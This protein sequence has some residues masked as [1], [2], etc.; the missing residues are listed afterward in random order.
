[1]TDQ[2]ASPA[3]DAGHDEAPE[4]RPFMTIFS[5]AKPFTGLHAVIQQNALESW[6]RLEPAAQV[7]LV[8]DEEGYEEAARA[9]GAR[10]SPG[11]ERNEFGTPLIADI[12]DT[13]RRDGTG[14][15][16]VFT[17]ADIVLPPGFGR[18]IEEVDWHFDRWLAVGRRI[19]LDVTEPIDYADP[20]WY[21]KLA[22][23][24]DAEGRERGDLCI[25]WFAFDR[26]TLNEIPAF[27]IGRTRYD[28]WLIW[29]ASDEGAAVVDV[30]GFVRVI[31]QNHDYGHTGG[32]IGAWE[33]PEARRAEQLLGHWSHYHSIA[34]AT[35][36]LGA[37]G[38]IR[39]APSPRRAAARARRVASQALRFS[40]PWRR[41]ARQLAS[42]SS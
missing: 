8:G 33:G 9:T 36:V 34:H 12:F 38:V 29:K 13:G 27:A 4:V 21:S 28:N 5:T 3:D 11:L 37:D 6:S 32:S 7:L 19:D 30:S 25:D 18:A 15:V 35:H 39:P 40:R 10:R 22:R 14:T 41:R 20:E 42:R 26:G 17:N 1:M 16:L 23:W 31:H 24:A 2:A